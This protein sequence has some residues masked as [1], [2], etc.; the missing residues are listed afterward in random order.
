MGFFVP[1]LLL[2][3]L[4]PNLPNT[5]PLCHPEYKPVILLGGESEVGEGNMKPHHSRTYVNPLWK[6]KGIQ[7]ILYLHQMAMLSFAHFK[8]RLFLCV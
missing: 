4:N 5:E 3:Y 1:L 2:L 7:Y 8:Y 6:I